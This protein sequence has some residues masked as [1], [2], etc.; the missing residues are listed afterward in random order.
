[1]WRNSGRRVKFWIFDAYLLVS[2]LLLML[3]WSVYMLGFVVVS[4]VFFYTLEYKGYTLPN[5]LRKIQVLLSGNVK[6]GVH[7]WR[8]PSFNK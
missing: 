7:W 8:R 3:S 1:M 6:R 4:L 2:F 5:A